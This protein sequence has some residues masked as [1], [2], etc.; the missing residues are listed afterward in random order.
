MPPK[1]DPA[2]SSA[3]GAASRAAFLQFC[4]K[5]IPAFV[6]KVDAV[7]AK[8]PARSAL[9]SFLGSK[10]GG[11]SSAARLLCK[12]AEAIFEDE[13][14]SFYLK[15]ASPLD[16]SAMTATYRG[17]ESELA[18]LIRG[19]A[20]ASHQDEVKAVEAAAA[21]VAAQREAADA[22]LREARKKLAAARGPGRVVSLSEGASSRVNLLSS[23]V[24]S[25]GRDSDDD[26][27]GGSAPAA[28]KVGAPAA[29]KPKAKGLVFDINAAA[30]AIV[31]ADAAAAA[32]GT[33]P[34]APLCAPSRPSA[35]PPA[36]RRARIAEAARAAANRK[37]KRSLSGNSGEG[38]TRK[39]KKGL[40]RPK[41]VVAGT[42]ES[43]FTIKKL[44][45][46]NSDDSVEV[47]CKV[48]MPKATTKR[49]QRMLDALKRQKDEMR[50]RKEARLA[51]ELR[52]AERKATPTPL[53]K[54]RSQAPG[55]N[56]SRADAATPA[57]AP[58]SS[59]ALSSQSPK[60]TAGQ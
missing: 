21:A 4:E 28:G 27:A 17:R 5:L 1:T 8:F 18:A 48:K 34:S 3:P 57:T 25:A 10:Y 53:K 12:L 19:K 16:A 46:A 7:L 59:G 14:A 30:A 20:G 45:Y 32:N 43:G 11:N 41:V 54:A 49:T 58:E 39:K 42:D 50:R 40:P 13:L 2:P 31:A 24:L 60:Q 38:A 35:P 26:V 29:V 44:V 51:A 6:S 37:R 15:I 22:T 47:S 55:E 9:L 36:A 56:A 23:K 33:A 52:A